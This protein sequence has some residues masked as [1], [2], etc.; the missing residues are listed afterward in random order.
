MGDANYLKTFAVSLRAI[1]KAQGLT[2]KE[3]AA[4]TGVSLEHLNKLERAAAAPSLSAMGA[5]AEALGAPM[6]AFFPDEAPREKAPAPV[7][8]LRETVKRLR[9]EN[10]RLLRQAENAARE[11]AKP[12][13]SEGGR[14]RTIAESALDVFWTATSDLII[15]YVSPS[16]KS[17]YGFEPRELVG[18]SLTLRLAPGSVEA[19]LEARRIRAAAEDAGDVLFANRMELEFIRKDGDT[20]WTETISRAILDEKGHKTGYVGYS[21][22]VT[23]RRDAQERMRRFEKI[24][25]ATS[26]LVALVDERF[27]YVLANETY[28]RSVGRGLDGV[29]GKSVESVVGRERF[30]RQVRPAMERCLAGEFIAYEGWY[31]SPGRRRFYGSVRYSPWKDEKTGSRYVVVGVRDIT[32]RKIAEEAVESRSRLMRA[33]NAFTGGLLAANRVEDLQAKDLGL[34]A[35]AIGADRAGLY[36]AAPHEPAA[37]GRGAGIAVWSSGSAPAVGPFFNDD[38]SAFSGMLLRLASGVNLQGRTRDFTGPERAEFKK[39]GTRAA[40]M[41]PIRAHD[42]LWGVVIL[43]FLEE[44]RDFSNDEAEYPKAIAGLIRGSI[45]RDLMEQELREGRN[46]LE[47]IINS[48]PDLL[49]VKDREHRWILVNDAMCSMAG[50]PR[51]ALLGARSDRR[52]FPEETAER[53]WETDERVF[54]TGDPAADEAPLLGVDGDSRHFFF[55]RSRYENSRGERFLA[56]VGR[57]ISAHKKIE[58]ELRESEKAT[59]ILYRVS[60]VV[61]ALTDMRE[62]CVL[63]HN[64]LREIMPAE[65]FFVALINQE[66]DSLEYVYFVN[67]IDRPY[68]PVKNISAKLVPIDRSNFNDFESVDVILEVLRTMHPTLVTRRVMTLT[69]M[70]SP[71]SPPQAWLGV[72]IRVRQ[73]ILGVM[74]VSNYDDQRAYGKKE[75]DLMASVAEQLAMGIE[76]ARTTEALLLAKNEA[77]RANRAKSDFLANMSHEIRTPMNAILG[78]T[79]AALRTAMDDMQREYVETAH[80]AA[81]RLLSVINSILD[82]SKIEAGKMELAGA[83]FMLDDELEA[84]VKTL[85]VEAKRK[86]LTLAAEIQAD[87]PRRL[88]G[89]AGRLR[90]VLVNLVGNALKFTEAG[91]AVIRVSPDRREPAEPGWARLLFEVED[92]GIGVPEHKLRDIFESFTQ[93]DGSIT[94]QFGG[95]G[96]GLSISRQLV[97]MMGGEITARPKPDGGSVFS[98]TALFA[99]AK[100]TT[101]GPSAIPEP[102][103]E[104]VNG[105]I[106]ALLAEDNPVNVKVA[107]MQLERLGCLCEIATTGLEALRILSEKPFDMVF[108]DVE[109]PVMD[110]I[111]A[112]RTIRAG[113]SR[114]FRV[115]D[116][117]IP[118]AALTAHVSTELRQQ[119]EEAG[120]SFFVG[121]PFEIEEL[122]AAVGALRQGAAAPATPMGAVKE[123]GRDETSP[124][125]APGTNGDGGSGA[126]A[127]APEEPVIDKAGAMRRLAITE[128][129]FNA[130][131]RISFAEAA[132]RTVQCHGAITRNDMAELSMQAHTLKSSLATVGA[133]RCAAAAGALEK[134][135]QSGAI[136]EC[137]RA[138]GLLEREIAALRLA[139]DEN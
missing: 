83:D 90:Q 73:E 106:R 3:L 111:T 91:G 82:L 138:L 45:R 17:V 52:V 37:P 62:L 130:L 77:D 43:E 93:A 119:C 129:D 131:L 70:T 21:R 7:K 64:L 24:V 9:V 5:L 36:M 75:L 10:R 107:V 84:V 49:Y 79:E 80:N 60:S 27:T 65:N 46:S 26:D 4:R 134:A 113:G 15:T 102:A 55:I 81:K 59:S 115:L 103:D 121:K 104:A 13:N 126:F 123:G 125:T 133:T 137:G 117:D 29:V 67:E 11:G 42:M 8:A 71:G 139:A 124:K 47:N 32:E 118:V 96:L 31:D 94:R 87:A 132:S 89:D 14:F 41:A 85:G 109:M 100:K 88:H 99:L 105:P 110:G 69:G 38:A 40:L 97:G 128:K 12:A 23:A 54:E 78:M 1:R 44:G 95:T 53:M 18:E 66:T 135:A 74:A 35:Q 2:Q 68:P 51:M 76:R 22:D 127:A 57:D 116:P 6:A 92:T 50:R 58:A 28:S 25:S 122:A 86:N 34:L 136:R 120:M 61:G 56:A 108:M 30:A 39:R 101:G 33:L 98:F 112:C 63:V 114:D 16:S 72:P 48:V 19:F 20:V